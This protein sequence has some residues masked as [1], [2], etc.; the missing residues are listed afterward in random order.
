MV[1]RRR[2][3]FT[4]NVIFVVP[5]RTPIL[6]FYLRSFLPKKP[7]FVTQIAKICNKVTIFSNST[8]R[9]RHFTD[10]KLSICGVAHSICGVLFGEHRFISLN[11]AVI[12]GITEHPPL[13]RRH[14][15]RQTLL[16]YI[17]VLTV[18]SSP[19]ILGTKRNLR[20]ASQFIFTLCNK[21]IPP[22]I[23]H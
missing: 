3:L 2:F 23:D 22:T 14:G 21:S 8:D 15:D 6:F 16:S 4:A 12:Y 7:V 18:F 20:Y 5:E 1:R 10:R 13:L 9:K 19:A 11:L 17:G